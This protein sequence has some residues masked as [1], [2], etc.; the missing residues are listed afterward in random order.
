MTDE[1]RL[2]E[3]DEDE[4]FSVCHSLHPEVTREEFHEMWVACQAEKAERQRRQELN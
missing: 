3:F 4:W 1:P 2:D